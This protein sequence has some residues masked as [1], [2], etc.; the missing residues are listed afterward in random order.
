MGGGG[1]APLVPRAPTAL[2]HTSKMVERLGNVLRGNDNMLFYNEDFD[3]SHSL[4][5]KDILAAGLDKI[6]FDKDNNFDEDDA[7]TIIHVRL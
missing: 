2:I 5:I 3:K 6:N 1:N 7:D 4:L